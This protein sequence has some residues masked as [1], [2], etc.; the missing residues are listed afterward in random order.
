MCGVMKTPGVDHSGWVSGNGSG[1]TIAP[2][3][4]ELGLVGRVG[5][6]VRTRVCRRIAPATR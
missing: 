6:S 1:V 5:N 2:E 4:E 3:D